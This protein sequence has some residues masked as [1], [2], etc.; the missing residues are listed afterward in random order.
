MILQGVRDLVVIRH[1]KSVRNIAEKSGPFF[2][3]DDARKKFGAVRDRLIPLTQ[4]GIRQARK[5]GGGLKR[6]FGIPDLLFHSGFLRTIET[7]DGILMAYSK[8]ESA[9]F[10]VLEKHL[11]RERNSGYFI[12]FTEKEV[13]EFFPWWNSYWHNHDRFLTA[14]FGG[15]DFISMAE[16]R[17]LTFLKSLETISYKKGGKKIFVVSHGRAILGLRYLLEDWSYKRMNRALARENPPNCSVTYYK[18]DA[19]GRPHLQFAN[20]IFRK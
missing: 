12:D 11:I 7:T 14:P 5:V 20:R 13:R 8:K 15:E 4:K 17:L 10:K 9:K 19:C 18:F 6:K 3:N 2:K 16:G 1:G